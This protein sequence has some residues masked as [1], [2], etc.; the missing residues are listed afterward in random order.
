MSMSDETTTTPRVICQHDYIAPCRECRPP[1]PSFVNAALRAEVA[2][3]RERV[4]ALE[5]AGETML[6][7]LTGHTHGVMISPQA[8]RDALGDWLAARALA[9]LA[10][11][12][13][14]GGR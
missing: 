8:V 9:A 7:L 5:G 10:D 13:Q 6:D 3:L 4:A 2:R 12:R 1:Y 11:E 14:G